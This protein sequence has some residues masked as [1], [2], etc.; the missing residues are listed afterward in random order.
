MQLRFDLD[1]Y[2]ETVEQ[3]RRRGRCP[4]WDALLTEAG[5]GHDRASQFNMGYACTHP[6]E[7][8]DAA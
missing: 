1:E 3:P 4:V 7:G 8:G 2:D 5:I 6:Y